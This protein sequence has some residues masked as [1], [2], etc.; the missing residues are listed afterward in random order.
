MKFGFAKTG[1]V[2]ILLAAA[3]T[4]CGSG[5]GKA[6]SSSTMFI[7]V[8]QKDHSEDYKTKWIV[9]YNS[10]AEDVQEVQIEVDDDN[11]WNLIETNEEYFVTY[12]GYENG[13][14]VIEQINHPG[15]EDPLR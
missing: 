15:D 9:G 1:L 5:S 13:R 3:L 11:L 2:F 12:E 4:G 7:R 14:Y 10:S 6:I 8:T